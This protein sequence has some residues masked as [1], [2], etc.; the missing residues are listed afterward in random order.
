MVYDPEY[1][2]IGNRKRLKLTI[3][4]SI[5]EK[6]KIK[7][8]RAVFKIPPTAN[9]KSF[10]QQFESGRPREEAGLVMRTASSWR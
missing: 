7:N 5:I 1:L 9:V 8:L 2:F 3:F 4:K 10:I 6:T